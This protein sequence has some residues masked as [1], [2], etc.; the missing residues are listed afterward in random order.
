MSSASGSGPPLSQ[1]DLYTVAIYQKVILLCILCYLVAA[2]VQFAVPEELRLFPLL[3]MIGVIVAATVF[4]F[5]LAI[6]LYETGVGI[7]L[8]ILTLVPLVGLIILLVVNGKATSTLQQHGYHVG[9]LG[10]NLSQFRR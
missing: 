7:V 4:V 2:A 6:K 9:L 1:Q 5:M 3:G 10:A 8:G